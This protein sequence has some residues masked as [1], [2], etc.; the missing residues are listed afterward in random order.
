MSRIEALSGEAYLRRVEELLADIDS[1]ER[2]SLLAE[3]YGAAAAERPVQL[4]ELCEDVK[5]P[6][7]RALIA[8]DEKLVVPNQGGAERLFNLKADPHEQRDLVESESQAARLRSMAVRFDREW[9]DVPSI[10]P[11]GGMKL[12]S[13]RLAQGPERPARSP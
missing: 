8:G 10:D 3:L 12:R 4:F 11:H 13:G 7:L 5:N 6:G 9:R 2:Q 1:D